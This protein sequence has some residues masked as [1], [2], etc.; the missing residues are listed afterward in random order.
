[1]AINLLGDM[2]SR[3]DS[4]GRLISYQVMEM[5]YGDR[6]QVEIACVSIPFRA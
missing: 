2:T 5:L 1:M 3:P 4:A 6:R